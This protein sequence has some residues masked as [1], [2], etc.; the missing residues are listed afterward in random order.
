VP[1]PGPPGYME[2]IPLGGGYTGYIP[3]YPGTYPGM[4]HGTSAKFTYMYGS[5]GEEEVY[6]YNIAYSV[7]IRAIPYI[8]Y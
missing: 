8:L 7:Y 4:E 6:I 1:Y 3:S 5:Y 2:S